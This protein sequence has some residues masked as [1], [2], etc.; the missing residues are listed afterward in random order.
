MQG[1]ET[2]CAVVVTYNRKKLL[3]DCLEALISQSRHV[4]AIYIIDNASTD[5]TPLLLQE[6]GFINE[7]PPNTLTKPWETIF[8]KDELL[9]HYVRMHKNTG[10][11]GGFHE[12][13][14]KSYEL[15]FDWLW[16]M[17]DDVKP[18]KSCLNNLLKHNLDYNILLPL[19]ISKNG[20]IDEY[21]AITYDL[22]NPLIIDPRRLTIKDK[23]EH[24]EDMP[25]IV[26]VEDFSFEGPLIHRS[27]I[28]KVG[29]PK[30]DFFIYGD[31]TEYAL[32][33]SKSLNER[34]V[35]I[36]SALMQRMENRILDKK[37]SWKH[38]YSI[39]NGNCIL[40]KYGTNTFVKIRPLLSF[41]IWL[42]YLLFYFQI[43]KENVKLLYYAL[44]DSWKK[45]LFNRY[46]P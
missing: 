23:F 30:K 11:A 39:R 3:I 12:G 14:K 44:V 22:T 13:I 46:K 34:I 5:Q 6:M 25:E 4:D 28:S 45:N 36:K 43:S 19:R 33:I 24:I 40:L 35:L 20:K 38:Y 41:F 1:K 15:G 2:V 37:I 10:G 21:A 8:K 18:I 42:V 16:I 31:D 29:Y 27:I 9:V 7:I 26:E 32:R 17:D